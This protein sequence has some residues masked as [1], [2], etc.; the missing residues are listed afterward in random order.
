MRW[1]A[2]AFGLIVI[3]LFDLYCLH[4][5][6]HTPQTLLAATIL[7]PNHLLVAGD[8]VPG[9]GGRY[10]TKQ[11]GKNQP[12]T[13]LADQPNVATAKTGDVLVVLPV[14]RALIDNGLNA[15]TQAVVCKGSTAAIAAPVTVVSVSCDAGGSCAAILDVPSANAA[16]LATL[17]P[18]TGLVVRPAAPD[19]RSAGS[20]GPASPGACASP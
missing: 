13:D 2:L 5:T 14:T 8:I 10:V 19:P 17:S 3:F 12:L 11:I 20:A 18:P 6:A 7:P 9:P 1:I 15:Q 16:S 4:R